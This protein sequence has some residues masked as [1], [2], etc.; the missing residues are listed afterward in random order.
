MIPSS[1]KMRNFMPYRGEMPPFSF[2]GIHTACVCGDNG[3]GKSALIDAIT[4]AL[5]GKTR[6]KSDDDLIHLGESD[7]EVEFEFFSDKQLYRIIRKHARPKSS[8]Y[9]GQ[10][11]LDLFTAAGDGF[12]T[13]SGDTK[14]Q[15]QQNIISLLK[16]DY[17]TF[18]NSAFLKQGHADE[19]T[20]Q[21]PSKRKEVLG[22]ILG[23]SVYDDLEE[24]ARQLSRRQ[25]LE[26]AQLESAVSELGQELARKT[27]VKESLKQAQAELTLFEDKTKERLSALNRLRQQMETLEN[28]KRQM[29]QLDGHINETVKDIEGWRSRIEPRKNRI[30]QYKELLS[31]RDSIEGG[32]ARFTQ[33]KTASDE[34]NKKLQMLNSINSRKSQFEEIINKAQSKLLTEH[35][36]AQNKIDQLESDAQKLPRLKDETAGIELEKQKLAA[37]KKEL[38]KK[39][40]ERQK[41]QLAV[42]AGESSLQRLKQEITELEE[43]LRLLKPCDDAR[44][45]LCETKL[46]KD[47]LAIIAGK[48]EADINNKND[49]LNS[50][51]AELS[52]KKTG[53]SKAEKEFK[54]LGDAFN[55]NSA[56]MQSKFGA[57]KQAVSKAEEASA[58]LE[59]AR[60]ELIEIENRLSAKDF[61]RQEQAALAE[62]EDE[63]AK[64]EYDP[65]KHRQAG[66][67]LADFEKYEQEKL[68]LDEAV[69]MLVL[70]QE[71]LARAEE[72]L[73]LLDSRM[74]NYNKERLSLSAELKALPHLETGLEQAENEYNT[75]AEK[76]KHAQEL[77]GALKSSMEHL[78]KQEDKQRQKKKRLGNIKKEAGIYADLAQAF[79]KKGIQIML[80]EIALPDIENE[81]NKLLGKMTD[82][83]MHIK[84]ETQRQSKK[85][86]A[87][88]TLDIII[89]DELG[90]RPYEMF[91]G[92]ETFRIDFAIRI[93]LSRLLAKRAGAPLPTLIIDEGFG[94]QDN[95]GIEKLKEAISSI[96][97][98]FEKIF[99]I[100]H[101][102]DFKDAFQTRIN[103]V[104]T[105]EGSKLEIS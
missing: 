63:L 62:L 37:F 5:W 83:R 39:N 71:E 21:T 3:N 105:A 101:I 104:K 26:I 35:A 58:S 51:T 25:Q 89:S 44:C 12:K 4:W 1:L 8:K 73:K 72:A 55:Q 103:V 78:L 10:S 67:T 9:S 68:R 81:A 64:L 97:D 53:L 15:T 98:D 16:M 91:S 20:K 75:A 61:S 27:D 99:V 29:A 23:L 50:Q 24:K 36:V 79:G 6:A 85:G 2:N 47:G 11:S 28:R 96:Q 34:F 74:D 45:P 57:L 56:S 84:F 66:K 40:E 90:A 33:A 13:I 69:K 70:E 52:V 82:N 95:T 88:E 19:F 87:L 18:I 46:G 22:S 86:V 31:R 32:Y 7:M 60:L 80:I 38:D 92:G 59:T 30:K 49:A 43:K 54:V 102:E 14:T 17:D 42:S 65:E 94:T 77:T 93:A 41:L 48:Y 100:T 76:Q